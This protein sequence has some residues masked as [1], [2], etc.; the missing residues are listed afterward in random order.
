MINLNINKACEAVSSNAVPF[1]RLSN[2]I[3]FQLQVEMGRELYLGRYAAR[4]FAEQSLK[5]QLTRI[6]HGLK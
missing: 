2:V 3:S 5:R 1:R 4:T 6:K